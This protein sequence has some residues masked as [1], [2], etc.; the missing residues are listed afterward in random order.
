MTRDIETIRSMKASYLKF[1][2]G[3]ASEAKALKLTLQRFGAEHRVWFQ[4][5]AATMEQCGERPE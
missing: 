4:E 3:G 1:R 2:R 5:A